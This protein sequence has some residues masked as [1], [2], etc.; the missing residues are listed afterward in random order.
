MARTTDSVS[1]AGRAG[2]AASQRPIT[3]GR[4]TPLW[5]VAGAVFA[6]VALRAWILASPLGRADADETVVGLMARAF[7]DGELSVFFWGQSYGG[8]AEP[9]VVALGFAVAG[10]STLALK[11]VPAL[12]SG[13]AALLVWRVGRRT[14]GE[15]AA[16]AAALLFLLYPP[17][18]WWSTKERGFYWAALVLG[19][20]VLL[21]ALRIRDSGGAP[22]VLDLA[23]LGFFSGLAWWTTPQSMYLVVPVLAWL[24]V[25][26]ARWWARAWPAV[27]AAVLGALPWIAWN[28]R[29][30]LSSLEE[31]TPWVTSTYSDRVEQFFTTLL[32][33]LLGVRHAF[34]HDWLLGPV[35][36]AI[37]V[38]ALVAFA[39]VVV[40]VVRAAAWRPVEPLVVV[41]LA[42]PFLFAI[43]KASHYVVEPRYALMVSPVVALLVAVPLV[44]RMR[45]VVAVV[46]AAGVGVVTIGA[47]RDFSD[48]NRMVVDLRPPRLGQL[49]AT[50]D[51]AGVDRVYADYWIAYPL[52]FETRERIVATPVD[53]VR[54]AKHDEMVDDAESGTY[55][56][57]GNSPR[58]LALAPALRGL[59]VGFERIETGTFAVYLLDRH[60]PPDDL[61]SVWGG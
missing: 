51:A 17:F 47:L 15:R 36:V 16:P 3:S 54:S 26:Q 41:A 52:T 59:G 38:A 11:L 31:P 14:V 18:L 37:T 55:V 28:L 45:Q 10:T 43:P 53:A 33:V 2:T 42:F 44:T 48:D 49:E 22:R 61:R 58:D 39:V 46:V 19:L 27:P 32:P 60:V 7:L 35:G 34:T 57:F 12:L 40:R 13:V 24:A 56:V 50:L 5:L 9:A 1:A 6:A 29:H 30:G 4:V 25:R 8:V 21:S 23:A 20:A